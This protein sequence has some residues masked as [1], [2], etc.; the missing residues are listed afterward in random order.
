MCRRCRPLRR[1]WQRL[2]GG[3]HQG[4]DSLYRYSRGSR[5]AGRSPTKSSQ[6]SG[7]RGG[8]R[9]SQ[10]IWGGAPGFC[11]TGRGFVLTRRR[12]RFPHRRN[13]P[14]RCRASRVRKTAARRARARERPAEV[15]CRSI[16]TPGTAFDILKEKFCALFKLTLSRHHS[17]SPH[18]RIILLKWMH[19]FFSHVKGY[20]NITISSLVRNKISWV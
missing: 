13:A 16:P 11:D 3:T 17:E 7:S 2:C 14:S 15:P 18:N 10:G 8:G 6:R 20:Q 9:S 5:R 19:S 4:P 12:Q 1:G